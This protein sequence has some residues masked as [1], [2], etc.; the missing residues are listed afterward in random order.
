MPAGPDRRPSSATAGFFQA[1]PVIP[2]AYISQ[3]GQDSA[4]NGSLGSDDAVL[5]NILNLYL[6]NP[7]PAALDRSIHDFARKCLDANTLRLMVDCETNHPTLHS[8]NTFGEVNN[9]N[10]LH[11]SEGWRSLKDIQTRAGIVAHGY[12]GIPEVGQYNVRIH[13]FALAHLW[14]P[15][16]AS[17]SCPAA[18]SDGAAILLSKH[19][20][21]GSSS[22]TAGQDP[23]ILRKVLQK[24]YDRLV[25]FDP[26]YAWTSGQWM[27]ERPGGSDVS[28]TET[29]ARLAPMEE[30]A[31]EK[32]AF[33]DSDTDGVG[34]PLG[35]YVIDGFKWFSSAT[36]ADMVVLLAQTKKGL[37]AFYAPMRRTRVILGGTKVSVM[38]GVQISRLK[39]KLG[40]K[41]LPTA[42]LEIRGMRG[43]LIGDEGKGVK[44]I[45]AIL[46]ATRLWTASGAVGG[47][48]RGLS[49][50]RAYA[51]VRK[52][53]GEQVLAENSQHL[54]WMADETVKYRACTHLA[55]LGVAL[56]GIAESG[57]ESAAKGTKAGPW[58]PKDKK[59]AE[60]LLRSLTPV[61]KAQCS[62][63]STWGL[64]ECMESLGGVGYCENVEDGGVMNIARILRDGAVNS[65]WEGT[66]NILGEDFVRVVK[67]GVGE[68]AIACLNTLLENMAGT[69]HPDF[70]ANARLVQQQWDAL[71]AWLS[72][73]AVEEVLYQGRVVLQQVQEVICAL[74]LMIDANNTGDSRD[75]VIADRWVSSRFRQHGECLRKQCLDVETENDRHIFLGVPTRGGNGLPSKL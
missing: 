68:Q 6:P 8:L 63:W 2:P 70:A 65:I 14:S 37:S 32:A 40:T 28:R 31:A 47:W 26:D 64:R 19:L 71:K 59:N 23:Q 58:L 42:E 67:G 43:W 27:T 60:L 57:W 46:N 34:M 54:K 13:Q 30:L 4:Q 36:D 69:I 52:I 25:S 18:M 74:L 48:A 21:L 24:A 39:N 15:S 55:F 72:S 35:P 56:L 22:T 17:V 53:K 12:R 41:G 38:N 62:L 51:Q 3:T 44:E 73:T 20:N 50:A 61:M 33:G 66:T 29:L 11:T 10:P 49:V 7:L 75:R 5:A 45:S 16:C 1:Y 9:I